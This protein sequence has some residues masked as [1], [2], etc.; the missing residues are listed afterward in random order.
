MLQET[1]QEEG[2]KRIEATHTWNLIVVD[3][4]TSLVLVLRAPGYIY[5]AAYQSDP[6]GVCGSNLAFLFLVSLTFLSKLDVV[7]YLI[8]VSCCP[9]FSNGI[10]D[11]NILPLQIAPAP[12]GVLSN[13]VIV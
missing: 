12:R 13:P 2:G 10:L 5:R 1:H 8:H 4:H 3:V 6:V 9:S 7:S 11:R